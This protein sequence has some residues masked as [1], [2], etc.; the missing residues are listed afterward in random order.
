MNGRGFVEEEE[1]RSYGAVFL[2]LIAVLVA[3]TVWALWQDTFS[4]HEWKRFKTDFY[5]M[6]I[7][8][9]QDELVDFD[10]ALASNPEYVALG[11]KLA[12]VR[13]S[14]S[15]G[16]GAE[17]LAELDAA[18]VGLDVELLESDLALRIT[19]GEVEEGWYY[20]EKAQHEHVSTAGPQAV[21]DDAQRRTVEGT[22]RFEAAKLAIAEAEAEA[23]AIRAEE[24]E[25]VAEMAKLA[26]PREAIE[27]R[28]DGVSLDLFGERVAAIPTIDQVVLWGFEKNNFEQWVARVDRCQNCHV[29]IDRAGFEDLE[30]PYKTHPDRAY[31]LGT[32]EVRKFGCTPC[33]GGQGPGIN[34][35]WHGHGEDYYW[36]DTLVAMNGKQ[37]SKC[38]TCHTSVQGMKGAETAARGEALFQELG[39]HGCHLVTGLEHLDKAGPSLRRVAAK[40]SPEW[41]VQWIEDPKAFRPRTRMPHFYLDQAQS[42]D[43]A[44][45]LL[46]ASLSDS[47]EWL[48]GTRDLPDTVDASNADLVTQGKG[49]V[50]SLG[51]LG[52]HGFESDAFASQ[53]ADDKDTAPNLA[54]IAEKT[55]GRWLYNWILDPRGYSEHARMPNLRLS[56]DEGV[57]ITSFLLTLKQEEAPAR[58]AAL[59]TDL[60]SDESVAAGE[61]LVRKYGCFGCH[62]IPGMEAE[63]RIGVELS[64]F[65]DKHIDELYFGNRLDIPKTWDDWTINKILEPRGYATERIEQVMP[66]FGFSEDDA[67]AI[68]VYL[69]S[70][71]VAL[72]NEKYLPDNDGAA[73]KIRRGRE[74]IARYN[75]QGCHSFDGKEGAI[76]RYYE[77]LEN[78]PPILTGEGMKLQPDWF[79]DF[80]E[81]PERLRPW[82]DVRM[83]SFGM[84]TDEAGAI[85]DYF[86]A[87]DGYELGAVVVQ[88]VGSTGDEVEAPVHS[89]VPDGAY[90]CMSCHSSNPRG[91]AP[92]EYRIATTGV[93]EDTLRKWL[94]E[95][96]GIETGGGDDAEAKSLA[97][98]L[99]ANAN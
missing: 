90:D 54:R 46:N 43:V 92:G 58:D 95:H 29:G 94:A 36:E 38:L 79:I 37:Q 24:L 99:G 74:V 57:A 63:G 16:A 28:L 64:A 12:E 93:D 44:A 87:L 53:V 21:L 14:I 81:K 98:Y 22:E 31:Y 60:A 34:S 33:H 89:V 49:L 68:S 5:R 11:E 70:R 51:C 55:D 82:L 17:R 66:K 35:V 32:H 59:R 75:C 6:A 4:R 13:E 56:E 97:G 50:E 26:K 85:V 20:L 45:Y 1:K 71:T 15:T 69:A 78:A 8:K 2:L 10:E 48:E 96:L 80:L 3:S 52:C 88:G 23:A 7:S 39:C 84:S 9:Y 40:V 91:T 42:A 76:R 86:N 61:K 25:V 67:R 83:P 72:I 30:N 73:A 18:R 41:L 47:M 27:G 62:V 19:K 65:G 77:N